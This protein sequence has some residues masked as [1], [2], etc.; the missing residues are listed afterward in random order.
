MSNSIQHI[1]PNN[2]DGN[3]E[4]S[5]SSLSFRNLW[6]YRVA[7][8]PH[9]LI[10]GSLVV[11]LAIIF[12]FYS[13]GNPSIW[14]DEA[15]SV[16][17]SRLPLSTILHIIWTSEA[18]MALYHIFMH[19]WLVVTGL[20]GINPIEFVVR[21]PSALSAALC[22][23]V[24]FA[25]G[26]RF[27]NTFAGLIASILYILCYL[28]L[29]YAQQTRAYAMQTLFVCL[30]WLALL[31]ALQNEKTRLRWWIFYI[32]MNVFAVYTQLFSLLIFIAQVVA[33]AGI[34]LLP[35][36][37]QATAR[38]HIK[39]LVISLFSA[40]ILMIPMILSTR[41]G[42][43]T[44]WLPIPH[45][46]DVYRLFLT[47]AHDDK[48][49]FLLL[50]LCVVTGGLAIIASYILPSI[51]RRLRTYIQQK[52]AIRTFFEQQAL[53]PLFWLLVC[54]IVI[55]IVISYMVSQGS[56]RLF[57]SRYLIVIV[58]AVFLLA[59]LGMKSLRNPL[60]QGLVCLMLLYLA[61]PGAPSYYR[62]AQVED[63][64]AA[65]HWLM[66]QYHNND[67]LICYDNVQGCQISMEY[68][69]H[70]YPESGAHF[71]P[72]YPGS[73][74]WYDYGYRDPYAH[75]TDAINP[76]LIATYAANHP[77]LFYIIG[78]ANV[79]LT[80]PTQQWLDNHYHST[81]QIVTPTVI[82]R[83]YATQKTS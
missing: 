54:W 35:N 7:R 66:Q 23:V 32:L 75:Y 72:D 71:T 20:F 55:P 13:L 61:Y 58:P 12:D 29:T 46:H 48:R 19:F 42:S 40:G 25:L 38:A 33:V 16:E 67:G 15:F 52:D 6:R 59:M 60:I 44:G 17:L 62:S 26:K 4:N 76:E 47:I 73:F 43:K 50:L 28:Q 21:F 1:P 68:Y 83:L 69:L 65:S 53:L 2:T 31:V 80:V 24:V 74:S 18:N 11:L 41:Q 3:V 9:T 64:N 39:G 30:A 5:P 81:D 79:S 77:R 34:L 45:I 14:F 36:T 10:L 70:A 22:A 57:S 56:T 51:P 37:W 82:V 63:W 8:L 49:Y 27:I 78:R